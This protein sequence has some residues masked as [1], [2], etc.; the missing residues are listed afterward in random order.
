M[1]G[2]DRE[3]PHAPSRRPAH[4]CM[5]LAQCVCAGPKRRAK[6]V[7]QS[8]PSADPRR[9]QLFSVNG[10]LASG[11]AVSSRNAS[12]SGSHPGSAPRRTQT[13]PRT[14]TSSESDVG[15]S[16]CF[17]RYL[18]R[19]SRIV[20]SSGTARVRTTPHR[21]AVA[22]LPFS[23]RSRRRIRGLESS[24]RPP[25]GSRGRAVSAARS[26]ARARCAAVRRATTCP[27]RQ[28]PDVAAR[29]AT[30]TPARCR[31]ATP[32]CTARG[33]RRSAGRGRGAAGGP[34][35]TRAPRH[36]PRRR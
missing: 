11:S 30:G 35:P 22:A 21:T 24:A 13:A 34:T 12:A 3:F 1:L 33:G 17:K 4:A 15:R 36:A 16:G 20:R 18:T 31:C 2:D 6:A 27:T 14:H 23:S 26:G 25:T 29:A 10:T 8:R 7:S 9:D 28:R 19:S 5:T 32:R